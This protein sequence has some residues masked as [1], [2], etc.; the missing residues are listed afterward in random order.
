MTAGKLFIR[1]RLEACFETTLG[2]V[3]N[4]LRAAVV[5]DVSL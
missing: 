1:E 4:P 2:V 5:K 3:D